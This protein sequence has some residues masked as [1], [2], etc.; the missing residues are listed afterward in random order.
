MVEQSSFSL[1]KIRQLILIGIM[2]VAVF[3][4]A[5]LSLLPEHLKK[6]Y[7]YSRVYMQIPICLLFLL[8]TYHQSCVK[9]YQKILFVSMLSLVYINYWF[10]L[11]SW[12]L[13][14]FTFPYE[15]TV[16]YSLFTLFVFR[17]SFKYGIAFSA[18]VIS[19]FI[20]IILMFYFN[21]RI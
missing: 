3:M 21:I 9:H 13:A 17:Q 4:I 6:Y 8:C 7:I 14:Q 2:F 12:Q 10:I 1:V 19:G 15:G 18:C 20:F 16:M 11:I 5:D